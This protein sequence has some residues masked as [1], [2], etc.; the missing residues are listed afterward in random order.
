MN[1]RLSITAAAAVLALVGP[2]AVLAGSGPDD[3]AVPRGTTF[4]QSNGTLP[5]DRALPRSTTLT[6]AP[7]NVVVSP[8]DRS[9]SRSVPVAR[10]TFV[11]V[12]N[13]GFD[14][15]DAGVG[16]A[17]GFGIALVLLGAGMIFVRRSSS[18]PVAT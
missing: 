15:T 10:P 1:T 11:R 7:K 18:R 13:G 2:S 6:V 5:D 17:S 8:D 3:R 4:S 12:S 9:F 16:A 14:W